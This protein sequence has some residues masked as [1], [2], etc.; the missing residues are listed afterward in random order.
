MNQIK[1]GQ[2]RIAR[3]QPLP[4]GQNISMEQKLISGSIDG[5]N[6]HFY[7]TW[8]IPICSLRSHFLVCIKTRFYIVGIGP[9]FNKEFEFIFKS[10]FYNRTYVYLGISIIR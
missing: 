3:Y 1:M 6:K 7:K 8:S 10:D 9:I 2:G 5:W 4:G